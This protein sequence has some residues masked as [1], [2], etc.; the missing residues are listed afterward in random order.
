MA[1]G[2]DTFIARLSAYNARHGKIL[3]AAAISCHGAHRSGVLRNGL[4]PLH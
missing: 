1:F 4:Y 2:P 3:I